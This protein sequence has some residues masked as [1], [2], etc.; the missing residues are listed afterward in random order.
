[1]WSPARR[2]S[3]NNTPSGIIKE[4]HTVTKTTVKLVCQEN[5]LTAL[6]KQCEDSFLGEH[7]ITLHTDLR[8]VV[9][10]SIFFKA[11]PILTDYFL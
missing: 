6:L 1:M 7:S 5:G 2:V 11:I 3:K 9:E 10:N 4:S 8:V